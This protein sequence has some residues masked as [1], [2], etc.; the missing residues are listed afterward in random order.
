MDPVVR[1]CVLTAA[2]TLLGAASTL[3]DCVSDEH[4][5]QGEP[6]VQIVLTAALN[7]ITLAAA[8]A[9]PPPPVPP[10]GPAAL[11]AKKG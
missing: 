6:S 9:L 4:A 5:A 8:T 1:T 11:A 10:I 2:S 3:I 7:L